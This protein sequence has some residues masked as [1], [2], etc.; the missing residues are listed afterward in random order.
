VFA[1]VDGLMGDPV[2]PAALVARFTA[3]ASDGTYL[4]LL[5][6]ALG[7]LSGAPSV[8]GL[9]LTAPFRLQSCAQVLLAVGGVP[10]ALPDVRVAAV[11]AALG[12]AV[13]SHS[14]DNALAVQLPHTTPP[15]TPTA[16][17]LYGTPTVEFY[18]PPPPSPPPPL[19]PS[20]RP[21]PFPPPS[22]SPPPA[23]PFAPPHPDAPPAPTPSVLSKLKAGEANAIL[24]IT[25][26]VIVAG[27]IFCVVVNSCLNHTRN[28]TNRA[29]AD[30]MHRRQTISDL[31]AEGRTTPPELVMLR[32]KQAAAAAKL[33]AKLA[34]AAAASVPREAVPAPLASEGGRKS[35]GNSVSGSKAGSRRAPS[36]APSGGAPAPKRG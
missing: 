36:R 5:A 35:R 4:G 33:N 29:L 27:L 24:G 17:V 31:L 21:P 3:A 13:A 12:A 1:Q 9:N 10:A 14:L 34:R 25:F 16:T 18:G 19:P 20:P 2:L 22:P 26:G 8:S 23:V 6:T 11:S 15:L 28:V 7:A 32:E 30:E